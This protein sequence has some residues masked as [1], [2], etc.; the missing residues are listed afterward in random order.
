M[1][2]FSRPILVHLEKESPHHKLA[3]ISDEEVNFWHL[4]VTF[5]TLMLNM[6]AKGP[7]MGPNEWLSGL[8]G[9]FQS[10]SFSIL[11]RSGYIAK[12]T[13]EDR[14]WAHIKWNQWMQK[15]LCLTPP[16]HWMDVIGGRGKPPA[17]PIEGKK[18]FF[19]GLHSSIYVFFCN[20][21]S[22]KVLSINS[23][24]P[25]APKNQHK[26][27]ECHHLS[28]TTFLHTWELRNVIETT[29]WAFW[30][31]FVFMATFH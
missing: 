10:R 18:K 26:A 2:S 22:P 5:L 27:A 20:I 7:A 29:I 12:P 8:W 4:K 6:S 11:K 16:W 19:F 31:N 15:Q 1:K 25:R 14:W 9:H 28:S 24:V 3:A 23:K 13:S 17:A 30:E 21:L